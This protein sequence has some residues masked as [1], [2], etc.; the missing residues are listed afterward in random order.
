[1]HFDTFKAF[2]E[3]T[4]EQ[5]LAE[6]PGPASALEVT[7]LASTVF[8]N[9]V[10]HCEPIELPGSGYWSQDSPTHVM[11]TPQMPNTIEVHWPGGNTTISTVPA[12]TREIA[13]DVTGQLNASRRGLN[14]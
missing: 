2:S 9:R 1:V 5:V 13:I 14:Q 7:T 11:A 6:L 10:D 12:E 8:L 4:I 3:A